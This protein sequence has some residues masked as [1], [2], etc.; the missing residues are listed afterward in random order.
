MMFD[1][2]FKISEIFFNNEDVDT[3]GMVITFDL[4]KDDFILLSKELFVKKNGTMKGFV[5][6]EEIELTLN[7]IDFLLKKK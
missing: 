1:K 7:G 6:D 5:L 3:K 4:D 2:L